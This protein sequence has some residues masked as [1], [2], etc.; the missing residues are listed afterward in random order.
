MYKY[1]ESFEEARKVVLP[2][3]YLPPDT[4]LPQNAGAPSMRDATIES[5]K[6]ARRKLLRVSSLTLPGVERAVAKAC[7]FLGVPRPSVHAFV[8]PETGRQ[9][10]CIMQNDE[11][12]IVFSS[13][14][15]ELMNED[16]LACIAG[17]EI[18]HF[19]LPEAHLLEPLLR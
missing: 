10:Y 12:V 5:K 7:R 19:L 4:V 3:L 17:H 1:L 6:L 18:G 16:E 11:P 8:S 15:I 9:A 13:A 14:L 2:C